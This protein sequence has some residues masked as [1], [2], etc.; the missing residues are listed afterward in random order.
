MRFDLHVHTNHSEDS[1]SSPE[2]ILQMAKKRSID[3]IAFLDHNTLEGYRR[4]KD[5][6]G[7]LLV[8][9]MEVTT[10]RGHIGALGVQEPV[11]RGLTVPETIDRIREQD[12][13]AV[14]VHPYRRFSGM[15]E[16]DIVDNQWDAIEGLN[17]RSWA[18][19]NEMSRRLASSM[20]VPVVGGSDSHRLKTVGKAWTFLKNVSTWEDVIGEIRK[21]NTDV[22]GKDRTLTETFYYV[23]RSLSHWIRTG[24]KRV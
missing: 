18:R 10:E 12:G 5:T 15:Q 24:F 19:R 6:E 2:D 20:D 7:V 21:G 1:K 11:Q 3:G 17:G 22:G 13:I 8:P 14:A 9:G 16:E 23:S 4:N